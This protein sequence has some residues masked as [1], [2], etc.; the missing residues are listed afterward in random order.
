MST[1]YD[2][3]CEA[4]QFPFAPKVYQLPIINDLA[5]L[6]RGGCYAEVGTGKTFMATVIAL[7]K[8]LTSGKKTIVVMPPILITGWCRWLSKLKGVTFLDYRGNPKKRKE[9]SFD[10]QFI[11]MSMDIFK[12]DFDS[13]VARVNPSECF[14][15]IDEATSIKNIESQN[16]KRTRHFVDAGAELLLLTGTPL[17]NPG[18]AY[19]YIKLVAPTI[20]RNHTQFENTHVEARDY[21]KNVKE[22]KNLDLLRDNMCVNTARVLRREVE[23]SPEPILQPMEYELSDEH[24]RLYRDLIDQMLDEYPDGAELDALTQQKLYQYSQQIVWNSHEFSDNK[25]DATGF[26][27]LDEVVQQLGLGTRNARKLVIFANYRMTIK[28]LCHHLRAFNPGF[29]NSEATAKMK[30]DFITNF[31]EKP[32]HQVL[33]VHPKSGGKGLDGLQHVCSDALFAEVPSSPIDFQ[34]CVGRLDREGQTETPIVRVAVAVSTVQA[35][36]YDSLLHK[37]ETAGYVQGSWKSLRKAL[38]GEV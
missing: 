31:I 21:F 22:W 2:I 20:Y 29:L 33:I 24:Y 17:N 12:R 1:P 19:A 36:L 3:V 13:I 11:C 8:A 37:D 32:D 38:Y 26:E 7:F 23:H 35:S 14:L 9:M 10:A 34:Q 16:Y 6:E 27:L 28:R 25:I 30:E 18:D 4:Y 5:L 15:I